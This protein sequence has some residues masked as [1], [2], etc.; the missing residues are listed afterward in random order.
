MDYFLKA[1]S[2]NFYESTNGELATFVAIFTS[3]VVFYPQFL[4]GTVYFS[5]VGKCLNCLSIRV[6][7][8]DFTVGYYS[9]LS[10]CIGR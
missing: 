10:K 3:H 1:G 5:S 2:S 4:Q 8:S 6:L 9:E 7:V